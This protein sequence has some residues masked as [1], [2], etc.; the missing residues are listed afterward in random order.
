MGLITHR[1]GRKMGR[2]GTTVC[3]AVTKV[4]NDLFENKEYLALFTDKNGKKQELRTCGINGIMSEVDQV[5]ISKVAELIV[6]QGRACETW[7]K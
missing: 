6:E 4:G 3:L 7:A 1:M 5:N 2:K